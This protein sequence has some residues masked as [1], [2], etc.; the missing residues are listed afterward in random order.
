MCQKIIVAPDPQSAVLYLAR[1]G[2]LVARAYTIEQAIKELHE[3]HLETVPFEVEC[4]EETE[5]DIESWRNK[6]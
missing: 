3:R 5:D 6:S 4:H 1:A 2:D